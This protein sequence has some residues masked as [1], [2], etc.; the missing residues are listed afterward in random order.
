ME[1]VEKRKSQNRGKSASQSEI[2]EA[3]QDYLS[4]ANVSTIA[5]Y[6]YRSPSFVKNILERIGVPQ[7][8]PSVEDRKQPAFLPENCVAEEFESGEIVWSAR[9]HAPAVV[10]KKEN[11]PLYQQKYSSDCYQIYIFEKEGEPDSPFVQAGIGGFY[12]NSLAYDLGKLS[13]LAEL[14]IDLKKHV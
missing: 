8:P 13:H 14:G 7:R 1:Y 4:G 6:L 5:K 10:V 3:V 11:K 12:A 9:Y 2:Q